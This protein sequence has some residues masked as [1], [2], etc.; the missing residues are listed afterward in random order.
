MSNQFGMHTWSGF[1]TVSH[2]FR[3]SNIHGS[4]LHVSL[5]SIE[6]N[7]G[8]HILNTNVISN[9]YNVSI[10]ITNGKKAPNL[11]SVRVRIDCFTAPFAAV[12]L[13]S[14]QSRTRCHKNSSLLISCVTALDRNYDTQCQSLTAESALQRYNQCQYLKY[15][16]KIPVSE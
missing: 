9:R 11:W 3:G 5:K 16:R 12:W 15:S 2:V 14:E 7:L 1:S 8:R 13:C 6:A 4:T 10:T